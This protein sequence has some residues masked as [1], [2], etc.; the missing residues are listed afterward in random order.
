[1]EAIK[2]AFY[3]VVAAASAVGTSQA[4]IDFGENR[5]DESLQGGND[6]ID[7]IQNLISNV[8]GLVG[9]I[10]V[11][12]AIYGGFLILTG[13]ANEENVSKGRKTLLYAVVGIIVIFLAWSIVSLVF[14]SLLEGN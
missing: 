7:G 3:G 8:L 1:M 14:T 2:K 4:A 6:G 11:A 13:G 10:A 12:F 9:I 5:V